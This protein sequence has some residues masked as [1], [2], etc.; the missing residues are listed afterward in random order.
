MSDILLFALLFHE[1]W[2]ILTEILSLNASFVCLSF[3]FV[4]RGNAEVFAWL[5]EVW[6]KNGIVCGRLLIL[7]VFVASW[8]WSYFFS[9]LSKTVQLVCCFFLRGWYGYFW[10]GLKKFILEMIHVTVGLDD[11][12]CFVVYWDWPCLLWKIKLEHATCTDLSFFI[13]Q[14]DTSMVCNFG[15][16]MIC[17]RSFADCW[18]FISVLS[19]D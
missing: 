5:K 15:P 18:L 19:W 13:K 6:Q 2:Y 7:F 1:F 4:S 16:H 10:F 3:S 9:N 14:W 8:D 12:W 17:G 11:C